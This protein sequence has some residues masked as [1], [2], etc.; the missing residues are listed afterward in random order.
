MGVYRYTCP[1]HYD[2]LPHSPIGILDFKQAKDVIDQCRNLEKNLVVLVAGINGVENQFTRFLAKRGIKYELYK[3]WG[4]KVPIYDAVILSTVHISH[5]EHARVREA[6]KEAGKKVFTVGISAS[7]IDKEFRKWM[8]DFIKLGETTLESKEMANEIIEHI[9]TV[10]NA[11]SGLVGEIREVKE[12]L[13]TLEHTVIEHVSAPQQSSGEI[14]NEVKSLSDRIGVVQVLN[15]K[16]AGLDA[17]SLKKIEALVAL[18]EM[19]S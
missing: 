15:T 9:L 19:D 16:L 4:P 12:R 1:S 7:A 13:A 14:L 6:Y 5:E 3:E 2:N 10:R 8:L 17:K 18:F 11:L